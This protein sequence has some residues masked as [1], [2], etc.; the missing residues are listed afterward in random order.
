MVKLNENATRGHVLVSQAL[1]NRKFRGALKWCKENGI[2]LPPEFGQ[3]TTREMKMSGYKV[4]TSEKDQTHDAFGVVVYCERSYSDTIHHS[5]K[6]RPVPT[7]ADYAHAKEKLHDHDETFLD[8][9]DENVDDEDD[10]DVEYEPD[11]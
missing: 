2:E 5:S 7:L 8:T 11:D 6:K 10:E 1:V 9:D 4:K 3:F